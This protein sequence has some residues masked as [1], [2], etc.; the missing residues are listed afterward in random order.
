VDRFTT[1]AQ[2]TKMH[3]FLLA[4]QA[5]L[6][7][8]GVQSVRNAILETEWQIN[9]AQNNAPAIREFLVEKKNSASLVSISVVLSIVSAM[10]VILLQ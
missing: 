10:T 7:D 5:T 3:Q 2:I 9:W 8:S 6:G 1:T 4:N